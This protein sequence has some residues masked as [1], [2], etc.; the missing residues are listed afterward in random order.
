[1]RQLVKHPVSALAAFAVLAS[2]P[3]AAQDAYP[4]RPIRLVVGF[5]A[6]GSTDI[7]ARYVADKLGNLLG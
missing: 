1:M 4:T 7:P 6:G 5:A 2:L 3:C